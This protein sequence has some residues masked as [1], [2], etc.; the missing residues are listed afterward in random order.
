MTELGARKLD[1]KM[2]VVMNLSRDFRSQ[3]LTAIHSF[4][5]SFNMYFLKCLLVCANKND[6]F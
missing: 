5:C 1:S 4:L 6:K 3:S 2:K